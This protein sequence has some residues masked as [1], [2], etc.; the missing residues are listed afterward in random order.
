MSPKQSPKRRALHFNTLD[1]LI[2][3]AQSI[4]GQPPDS[5]GNWSAAQN[6][7]HVALFIDASTDGFPFTLPAPF[8]IFGRLMRGRFL[9]NGFKP[10]IKP[11]QK[12]AAPFTPPSDTTWPDAL[13]H[14]STSIANAKQKKMTIPSPL[15]GAMSHEQWE[16]LHCRH[17][18]LHFGF[19]HP[20]T[21]ASQASP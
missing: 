18:E 19:I 16:Q 3:D 12:A 14:L 7:E 6:V 10:G 1:D 4:P 11:P 20:A 8:R 13:A 9:N 5:T 2:H 15:F 21:N 17:A